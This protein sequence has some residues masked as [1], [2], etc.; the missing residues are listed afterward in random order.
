VLFEEWFTTDTTLLHFVSEVEADLVASYGGQK[1]NNPRSFSE[2]MLKQAEQ[3]FESVPGRMVKYTMEM[4]DDDNG[5]KMVWELKSIRE[6]P[7]NMAD[8]KISSDYEKV[9][10]LD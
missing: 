1:Q 5:F 6:V 3:E 2:R 4:K 10:E 8:F 7:F 9:D